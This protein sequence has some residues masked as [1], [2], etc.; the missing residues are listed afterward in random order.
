[1]VERERERVE[2]CFLIIIVYVHNRKYKGKMRYLYYTK[3]KIRI[4]S[5]LS[6]MTYVQVTR[7]TDFPSVESWIIIISIRCHLLYKLNQPWP[8]DC[9][10]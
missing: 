9:I 6:E 3:I 5:F 2:L 1:M 7:I 8:L 10:N 4:F